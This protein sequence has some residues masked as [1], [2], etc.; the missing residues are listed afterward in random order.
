MLD[1]LDHFPACHALS[2]HGGKWR[3]MSDLELH[4]LLHHPTV[5]HCSQL[6][7]DGFMRIMADSVPA[8]DEPLEV[9][10]AFHINHTSE[11]KEMFGWAHIRLP[12]VTR[13]GLRLFGQPHHIGGAAFLTAHTALLELNVTT[14]FVSIDELTTLLRDTAALPQLARLTIE[15]HAEEQPTVYDVTRLLTVLATTAVRVS[16][17]PRPMERLDLRLAVTH[18]VF[19]GAAGMAGLTC[20]RV[21]GASLGWLEEWSDT[22][23]LAFPLLEQ[24]SVCTAG[25]AYGTLLP[26]R[27]V[28][29]FLECMASCPLQLL[30]I[31]SREQIIFDPAAMTRLAH[32][33]HLQELLLSGSLNADVERKDWTDSA[34]FVGWTFGCLPR[35]QAVTLDDVELSADALTAIASAA[36]QL[37][38][39]HLR[40]ITLSC[41]PAVVCAI[42]G[43][44]CQQIED[45]NVGD[46]SEHVWGHA[47]ATGIVAAYQSAVAA[48]RRSQGYKPFTQLRQFLSMLCSCPPP[49]VWYALLSLLQSAVRL[50]S[51]TLFTSDDPLVM[52]ALG[53]LPSL[54]AL[55]YHCL[56][57][58][59]FIAFREQQCERTG[60]HRRLAP[61]GLYGRPSNRCGGQE[62]TFELTERV[63][64]EDPDF[65]VDKPLSPLFAA[66]QRSLTDEQQAVL[67]RWARGDFEA[68]EQACATERDV[69]AVSAE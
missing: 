64:L 14:L 32:C 56:L 4:A 45:I 50:R 35:L 63:E 55:S 52:A 51:V 59:S 18:G 30:S 29:S 10:R 27:P 58:A 2:L 46:T 7:L 13:L 22:R 61:N 36:P 6:K 60:F 42:V 54:T 41:H 26:V 19:A 24:L 37:R 39:L 28:L 9:K 48:A 68:G 67:A 33:H 21:D 65:P 44:Y 47:Q 40:S 34:L 3:R 69:E 17:A 5:L 57:P 53:R 8:V 11:R 12:A 49:S 20:L 31:R 23:L 15:E 43:G 1:A 62:T 66:Y 25:I 16:G 38:K